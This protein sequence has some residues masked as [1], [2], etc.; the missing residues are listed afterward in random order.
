VPSTSIFIIHMLSYAPW[1]SLLIFT[2]RLWV[3]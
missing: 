3:C 2:W 1:I